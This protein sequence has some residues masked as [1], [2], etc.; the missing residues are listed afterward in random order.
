MTAVREPTHA[1]APA[2]APRPWFPG[3]RPLATPVVAWLTSRLVVLVPIAVANHLRGDG[4][5]VVDALHLWDG[6]WYLDAAAGYVYPDVTAPS[7]TQVNIAFFPLFP[8]L[9]RAVAAVTGLTP[10]GASLVVTA[11]FGAAALVVIWLL[12]H[13]LAGRKV[14]DRSVVLLAFF[15]GS[16][17]L[18]LVY[19][20][21]V[22]LTAAAGSLLALAHRRWVLA[23]VLGALASAARPNGIAVALACGVAAALAIRRDGDYAAL[24]APALAPLGMGLYLAWLWL[25]TG[26]ADVWFR[27]QRDGWGEGIDFGAAT[28]GDLQ[29]YWRLPTDLDFLNIPFI[30][31]LRVV[32]LLFLIVAV[33]LMIRWRPPAIVWTYALGVLAPSLLSQTLGARPRFV[34]TAFPVVVAVAWQFRGVAFQVV[35]ACSAV[36]LA[37]ATVIYTTPGVVAP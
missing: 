21:G 12:V 2:G 37:A 29:W 11:V 36:L 17:A 14:A 6:N 1:H 13:H 16:I 15:P 34:F 9:I 5:R 3:W 4:Q 23:G 20:E 26:A 25:N 22:M 28:V 35:L 10:L 8:L 32:G 31:H 30:I 33:V 7:L 27:V 18:T 19:S 24:A